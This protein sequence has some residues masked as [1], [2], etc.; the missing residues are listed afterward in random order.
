MAFDFLGLDNV[1]FGNFFANELIKMGR[2]FFK[3]FKALVVV[4]YYI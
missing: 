3:P 2:G 4:L 1:D